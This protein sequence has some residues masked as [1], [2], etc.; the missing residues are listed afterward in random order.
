MNEFLR[1]A[2]IFSAV[3]LC[4]SPTSRSAEQIPDE[5]SWTTAFPVEKNELVSIGRNPFF[6]LEPGYQLVLEDGANR[7]VITV[8]NETRLVDGIETR[9][10]E[11]RESED[12]QLVEVSRNY[13]AISKRTNSVYYFGEEVDEYKNGAIKSHSGAWLSGRNDAKFGLIMP[14]QN[15]LKG[16]YY[17]EIAPNVA[18]DRAEIVSLRETIKTPAGEFK[19]CL[20]TRETTPLEPDVIEYKYYAPGIGLVQEESLKLT[21]HG[22]ISK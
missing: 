14:G 19:N 6:I 9:V 8:L 17:Q 7:L 13:F 2:I 15:L 3:I 20:K 16:K 22:I 1:M 11:E 21:K 4:G 12:G 5:D 10:I 18:L